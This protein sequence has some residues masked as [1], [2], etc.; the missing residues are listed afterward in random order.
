MKLPLVNLT[1]EKDELLSICK[2]FECNQA[3]IEL[4]KRNIQKYNGNAKVFLNEMAISD[5]IGELTFH[6]IDPEKTKTPHKDGNIGAS[7]LFEP[8][9]NYPKEKYVTNKIKVVSTTLNDYC[10][11]HN[12]PDLLWMDLQGAELKALC[13]GINIIS[14]VKIIHLEVT[15][16]EVFKGQ[17]M[18]YQIHDF[19]KKW[20]KLYKLKNVPFIEKVVRIKMGKFNRH[21]NIGHWFTDAI[22]I[23]KEVV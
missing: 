13:G 2:T 7:S 9:E 10:K 1:T 18:F 17:A 23:N 8:N 22:Y 15:F 12:I 21:I 3:A 14:I 19:L 4:C 11:T 5:V 20:F 6:S 16:R